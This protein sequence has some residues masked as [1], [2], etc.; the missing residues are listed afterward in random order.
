MTRLYDHIN[1]AKKII[2]YHGDDFNT[3]KI[4]PKFM[5]GGNNQEGVGIYFGALEVAKKYGRDIVSIDIN[6]RDFK[7]AR[8]DIDRIINEKQAVSI[9]KY[10]LKKDSDFWYILTDYGMEISEPEDVDD[11]HLRELWDSMKTTEAR[12]FQIEIVQ[13]SS[14]EPFVEAWNKFTKVHGL[15][16][17][18]SGFYSVI[19]TKYKLTKVKV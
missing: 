14:V 2:V 12:N 19:N 15:Y 13:N 17:K 16:E 10:I 6:P 9:F 5:F 1:E 3:T 11:Y 18:E 7:D 4:D 8:T